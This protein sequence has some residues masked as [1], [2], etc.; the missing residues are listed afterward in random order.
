MASNNNIN[1]IINSFQPSSQEE[2]IQAV[3]T[4]SNSDVSNSNGTLLQGQVSLDNIIDSFKPSQEQLPQPIQSNEQPSE[5]EY[6]VGGFLKNNLI[7]APV[8]IVTGLADVVQH[9]IEYGQQVVDYYK[10]PNVSTGEKIMSV[11]DFLITQPLTGMNTK[12]LLQSVQEGNTLSNL[13]NYYYE[14]GALPAALIAAPTPVGK[15]VGRLSKGTAQLLDTAILKNRGSELIKAIKGNFEGVNKVLSETVLDKIKLRKEKERLKSSL[16]DIFSKHKVNQDMFQEL[17]EKMEGIGN[18][19]LSMLTPEESQVYNKLKPILDD[20]DNL[21]QQYETAAPQNITEIVTKGVRRSQDKGINTTY[22][23][24]MK[25]YTDAGLFDLGQYVT[26]EGKPLTF[27][28]N[29]EYFTPEE[30]FQ[31]QK[32]VD[33]RNSRFEIPRENLEL[34]AEEGLTNPLARQFY[35]DYVLASEGKLQRISHGLADVERGGV[36]VDKSIRKINKPDVK[37]SERAYGNASSKNIAEEWLHPDRMLNHAI[38][39]MLRNSLLE[40]WWKDYV[41]AGKA[42]TNKYA[43]PEDMRFV[44]RSIFNDSRAL[45]KLNNENVVLKELPEGVN[46]QDYAKIDKYTLRAYRDLFFPES[47][48]MKVPKIVQDITYLFKQGLLASG[49]YLG[50]NFFGGLHSFVTNSNINLMNDITA[51]IKTKGSI[52][53][54]LAV[55]RAKP[56]IRDTRLKSTNR[57]DIFLDSWNK[58][59]SK[60]EKFNNYAGSHLMRSIDTHLQNSFAELQANAILRKKGIPVENRNLEWMRNNMSKE[61]IYKTLSDIEKAA[62]IYG[63]QTLLPKWILNTAEVG[64]PFFRWI[65][66]ATQSSTWLLK[67]NPVAYGYLQGAVLGNYAWDENLARADGLNISNP[68]SGKIY[69]SDGDGNAKVTETEIIPSLTTLKLLQDPSRYVQNA[70]KNASL[71][72]LIDQLEPTNKYGRLKERA[73]WKDITPDFQKNVRYK[74]GLVKS[75]TEVDEQ[76]AGLL[77]GSVPINFYNKTLAPIIGGLTGRQYYQPYNDQV[78]GRFEGEEGTYSTKPYGLQDVANRLMTNYEHPVYAGTDDTV[79]QN[80]IDKANRALGRRR[81]KQEIRAE[82]IAKRRR[83]N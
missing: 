12:E 53:E 58:A 30:F 38:N 31:V 45:K 81:S 6:T 1:D 55:K 43:R 13:G 59:N 52:I 63:E 80:M 79:E 65:D 71:A 28:K 44:H 36:Q 82:E 2:S 15:G 46:P 75:T 72:F 11:S 60:L 41:S 7:D 67:E 19:N 54:D 74:D 37:F 25:D 57:G 47:S 64:N 76:L 32:P 69:R 26:K 42:I 5:Q 3:N 27:P 68:Q 8:N 16:N 35:E 29:K 22:Q 23:Q 24:V 78:L 39:G 62:L 17:V 50:G 66:Q 33:L 4:P 21:A 73:D 48:T 70:S 34:L 56:D 83:G 40:S 9:P 18:K 20:W 14:G 61:E 49:L 77:K 10:D 51:A